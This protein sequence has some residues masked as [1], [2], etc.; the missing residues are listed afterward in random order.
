LQLASFQSKDP[1]NKIGNGFY[2]LCLTNGWTDTVLCI[3]EMLVHYEIR[4]S[5]GIQYNFFSVHL[6]VL[7]RWLQ[8]YMTSMKP[9]ANEGHIQAE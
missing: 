8:D 1:S 9:L 5:F 3:K 4:H 6:A 2:L 7:A